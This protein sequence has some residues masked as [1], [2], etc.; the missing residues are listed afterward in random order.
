MA[1]PLISIMSAY[2]FNPH[3]FDDLKLPVEL[4]T[5]EMR[6]AVI[7][8]IISE[9]DELQL[10]WSNP[11]LLQRLIGSWS[12][13]RL[14][15]W[16]RYAKAFAYTY[17]VGDNYNMTETYEGTGTRHSE[18][19]QTYNSNNTGTSS[20]KNTANA[21]M[22]DTQV[23]TDSSS[24]TTTSATNGGQDT[25]TDGNDTSNYTKTRKGNTGVATYQD[26]VKAELDLALSADLETLI[27]GEFRDYFCVVV[28]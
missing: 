27:I 5:A 2:I 23:Q 9:C 4:N 17:Q 3:L 28:Y 11:T 8:G 19:G 7:D 15:N 6:Q 14:P 20:D 21:Y 18:S 12:T 22:S 26:M 16:E 24:G 10:V 1:N 25:T 13:R